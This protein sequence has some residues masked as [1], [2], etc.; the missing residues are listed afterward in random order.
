MKRCWWCGRPLS[1]FRSIVNAGVEITGPLGQKHT[2][3][4]CCRKHAEAEFKQF[5]AKE[6][7]K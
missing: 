2:V 5:T 7:V 3:H 4:K 1:L 6:S